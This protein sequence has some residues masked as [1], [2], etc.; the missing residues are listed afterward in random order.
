MTHSPDGS[1]EGSGERVFDVPVSHP[2]STFAPAASRFAAMGSLTAGA[3]YLSTGIL[4]QNLL[5]VLASYVFSLS[6]IT[7][8]GVSRAL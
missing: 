1:G 3:L 4:Q 6:A 2:S 7:L 5:V 8:E